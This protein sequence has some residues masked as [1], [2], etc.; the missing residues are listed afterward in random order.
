MVLSP[1]SNTFLTHMHDSVLHVCQILEYLLQLSGFFLCPVFSSLELCLVNL[2]CLG[3]RGLLAHLLTI[4]FLHLGPPFLCTGLEILSRQWAGAITGLASVA[5]LWD[6]CDLLPRVQCPEDFCFV[7][8]ILFWL[9][10]KGRLTKSL[11]LQLAGKRTVKKIFFLTFGFMFVIFCVFSMYLFLCLNLFG[12][13][14][15]NHLSF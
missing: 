8:L 11:V 15:R 4:H 10:Q 5:F 3:L 12:L 14:K 1:A 13:K 2:S 9:L 6:H 7:H